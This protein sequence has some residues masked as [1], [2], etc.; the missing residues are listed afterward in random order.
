MK[1]LVIAPHPDDEILGCGGTIAKHVSQGDEVYICIV[2]QTYKPDWSDEYV[3]KRN[4]LIEKYQKILGIKKM[5]FLNYPTV[6]LD[7]IPQKKINDSLYKIVKKIEPEVLY[8]PHKGDLIKDHRLIH[9]A[10]LVVARPTNNKIRR[11]LSYEVLSE[12]EWGLKTDPFIPNVYVNISGFL[13]KKIKA[14]KTYSI[15]LKKYPHPRSEEIIEALAKKR[16]SEA[17][18]R[19][20]ESFMLIREFID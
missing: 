10:C 12:T 1:V 15:E 14:M 20:A 16:G 17:G 7:T 4:K 13:E 19:L 6:K 3:K 8:I 5:L 18:M 11:V 2:T 9:E